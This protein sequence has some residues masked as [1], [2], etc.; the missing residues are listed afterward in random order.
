MA[1]F[2]QIVHIREKHQLNLRKFS[3][4]NYSVPFQTISSNSSVY[5][6]NIPLLI[7]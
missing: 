6:N 4:E 3:L 2:L 7:V 5:I 1:T